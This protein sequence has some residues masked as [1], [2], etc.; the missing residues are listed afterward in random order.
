MR[1]SLWRRRRRSEG[2]R[3]AGFSTAQDDGDV[4]RWW[5][6]W[7]GIVG[8]GLGFGAEGEVEEGF[9]FEGVGFGRAGGGAGGG[10]AF[11]A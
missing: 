4:L 5:R 6:E 10:G 1:R 11:D 9:L 2:G 7:V 3:S 8:G